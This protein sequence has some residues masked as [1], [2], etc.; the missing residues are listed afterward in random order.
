LPPYAGWLTQNERINCSH[1]TNALRQGYV[2]LSQE[3]KSNRQ[4]TQWAYNIALTRFHEVWQPQ[5][6]KIIGPMADMLNHAAE[7]NC[8]ISVDYDGNVNV[9][10]LYDVPAGTPLSLSY[11]DPTNPTPLFAQYGF[12]PNDCSTIFCK[13]MQLEGVMYELNYDFKDLLI[14]TETGEIAPPVW[15]TFL[16]DFLIKND[17]NTAQQF[18]LAVQNGDESTKAQYHTEYFSY[19]IDALKKHVCSILNDAGKLTKKANK[20]DLAKHPR[21]PVIVAH[22]QL[23]SQTFGMT[24]QILEQMS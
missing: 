2:P 22:N 9:V 11:G 4:V 24:A 1:F 7:P 6:A 20:M 3:T 14:Q 16:Y 18:C 21:V 8:G 17:Y 15:D 13:A 5:R 23:V 10:A 19:T 12:L